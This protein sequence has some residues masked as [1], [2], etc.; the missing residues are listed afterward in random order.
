MENVNIWWENLNFLTKFFYFFAIPSTVILVIQSIMTLIGFGMDSDTDFD[1]GGGDTDFDLSADAGA[2]VSNGFHIDIDQDGV[3]DFEALGGIADFRFITF[4]GIIAFITMFGWMGAALS[5][6]ALPIVMIFFFA[7][8]AGL[9]GMFIIAMLFY[10]IS[11]L[12]SSGNINYINAVGK[13]GTVYIPIP[14]KGEGHGKIELTLQER[15]IE[16]DAISN[17]SIMIPTGT[18][19]QVVGI[20]DTATMIVQTI[21]SDIQA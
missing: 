10:G 17:E 15:F 11:K 9:V 2:D 19:V 5:G 1:A 12:Q 14:P 13:I 18:P 6:T 3:N 20:S 4:R 7:L 21:N 8:I 16:V